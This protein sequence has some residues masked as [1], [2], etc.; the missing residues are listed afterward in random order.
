M[1]E[2]LSSA[3]KLILKLAFWLLAFT[4]PAHKAL[5]AVLGL[6][7]ADLLVG[8]WASKKRGEPFV[9]WKLRHTVTRK[10]APYFVAITCALYI[11]KEFFEAL[12]LMKSIAGFIAIS[13]GKS[14]FERLGEITGLDFWSVIREKLQPAA[15]ASSP[16]ETKPDA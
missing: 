9:S 4:Q 7:V 1:L 10:I 6:I 5:I 2:T 14:I 11:E 13:E 8:V 16:A 12:P 15:K 3:W